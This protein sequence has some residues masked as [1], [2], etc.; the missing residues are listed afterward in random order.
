MS[1]HP[2]KSTFAFTVLP[3]VGILTSKFSMK[4]FVEFGATGASFEVS[5]VV[6]GSGVE[7]PYTSGV[8][9][10]KE[11][12]AVQLV[13]DEYTAEKDLME[14]WFA[15]AKS[16]V[17]G[18]RAQG[19]TLIE[20]ASD[21]KKVMRTEVFADLFPSGWEPEP[22]NKGEAGKQRITWTFQYSGCRSI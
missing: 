5:K 18:A 22:R 10:A 6:E 14:L 3:M 16:G 19:C 8:T 7:K 20:Y 17:P 12:T 2:E 9:K 4:S 1:D 21:G 11:V 15:A 13:G